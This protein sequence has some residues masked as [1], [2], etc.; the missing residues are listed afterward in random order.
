MR[1]AFT[2]KEI[3][4]VRVGNQESLS[5]LDK[6]F[7]DQNDNDTTG[8]VHLW[9]SRLMG[10]RPNWS[11]CPFYIPQHR[12]RDLG[13]SNSQGLSDEINQPSDFLDPQ[14]SESESLQ[15]TTQKVIYGPTSQ[16]FIHA[17][18][19]KEILPLKRAGVAGYLIE[20]R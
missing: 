7:I 19:L 11:D 8:A 10:R 20:W 13:P 17:K 1:K 9:S 15:R 16:R 3:Y 2:G 12:R 18:Q 4:R 5:P 14:A 6:I